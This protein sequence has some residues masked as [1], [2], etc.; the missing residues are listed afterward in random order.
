VI[1]FRANTSATALASA[2][3]VALVARSVFWFAGV[4]VR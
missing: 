4:A 2:E 1:S 3:S